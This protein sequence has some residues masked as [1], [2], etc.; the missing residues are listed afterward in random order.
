MT[1]KNRVPIAHTAAL[2]SDPSA[3]VCTPGRAHAAKGWAPRDPPS[4]SSLIYKTEIK[5]CGERIDNFKTA[6]LQDLHPHPIPASAARGVVALEAGAGTPT[7]SKP[8]G[9]TDGTGRAGL[10]QIIFKTS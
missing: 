4:C 9:L 7:Q 5:R 8:T 2:P 10:W 1:E 6:F 3:E